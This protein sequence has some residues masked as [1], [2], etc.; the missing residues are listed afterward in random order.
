M[1]LDPQLQAPEFHDYVAVVRGRLRLVGL[2]VVLSLALGTLYVVTRAPVYQSTASVLV[3]NASTDPGVPPEVPDGATE[4]QVALSTEV[5]DDVA[6]NLPEASRETLQ[7]GLSVSVPGEGTVLEF[8]FTSA[9]PV[10]AREAV[11]GYSQAYTEYRQRRLDESLTPQIDNLTNQLLAYEEDRARQLDILST[12]EPGSSQA[13]AAETHLGLLEELIAGNE[14]SLDDLTGLV[15]PSRVIVDA[16]A[17]TFAAT[18][19]WMILI[20]AGLLGLIIGIVLAFIFEAIS[21]RV[22][23]AQDIERDLGATVLGMV[24]VVKDDESVLVTR[25][26]HGSPASE[27]FRVIRSVLLFR[28]DSETNVIMV[29]S[30]TVAEGK[31]STAAN[32]AAALAQAEHRTILVSADC[33]RPSLHRYFSID[34]RGGLSSTLP[35]NSRVTL[36]PS[37]IDMLSIVPSGPPVEASAHLFESQAFGQMVASMR[38]RADFIIIDVPPLLIAD[39]LLIAP[40]VDGVIVV[41]DERKATKNQLRQTRELLERVGAPAIGIV[42]NRAQQIGSGSSYR[43]GVGGYRYEPSRATG[44]GSKKKRSRSEAKRSTAS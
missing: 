19:K 21:G 33:R 22:R 9:D 5:L 26:S 29:T 8:T 41:V 15:D 34:D 3:Q 43:Y 36:R 18:S 17:P 16:T 23:D 35:K 7:D 32:L 42:I 4:V 10:L 11:R 13:V 1:D 31:S 28:A 40:Y 6:T 27:A 25:D 30:G 14:R 44:A 20:A 2:C 24:P 39:P 12:A 38:D 37:G